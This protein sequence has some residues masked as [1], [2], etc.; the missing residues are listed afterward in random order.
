MNEPALKI[1][2]D[3]SLDCLS[4]RTSLSCQLVAA[5]GAAWWLKSRAPSETSLPYCRDSDHSVL[6]GH[7]QLRMFAS[8]NL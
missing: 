8:V 6:C 7:L 4:D 2:F 5:G 1:V 3:I